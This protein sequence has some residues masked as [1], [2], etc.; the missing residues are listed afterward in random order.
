MTSSQAAL[1]DVKASDLPRLYAFQADPVANRLVGFVPRKRADFLKH[2]KKILAD[3]T[4]QKKTV[5]LGKEIAGYVVCFVRKAPKREV[6]YWIA[7]KHW[8]KGLA[9]R[10]LSLFLKEYDP[11]PLYARVAKHNAASLAVLG[12]CGFKVIGEDKFSNA[13][14]E[15]Y[16]E[17]VLKLRSRGGSRA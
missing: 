10:A 15:N 9:T 2:W 14:G 12:K 13:A 1:R 5:I 16:E 4:L 7:R 8:G 17:F 6:G 11:R 3:A